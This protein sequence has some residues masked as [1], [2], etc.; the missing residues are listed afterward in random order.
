MAWLEDLPTELLLKILYFATHSDHPV[1]LEHPLLNWHCPSSMFFKRTR[2]LQRHSLSTKASIARVCHRWNELSLSWL[3]EHITIDNTRKLLSIPMNEDGTVSPRLQE[4]FATVRRLDVNLPKVEGVEESEETV[5]VRIAGLLKAVSKVTTLVLFIPPLHCALGILWC[6][7][8][9]VKRLYWIAPTVDETCTLSAARF[10]L[11]SFLDFLDRHPSLETIALPFVFP[12]SALHSM[13]KYAPRTPHRSLREIIVQNG[14]QWDLFSL[15]GIQHGI[16]PGVVNRTVTFDMESQDFS[17]TSFLGGASI[18]ITELSIVIH[19]V[20]RAWPPPFLLMNLPNIKSLCPNLRNFN[21]T[22]TADAQDIFAGPMDP[23]IVGVPPVPQV[24]SVSIQR[25]VKGENEMD[26]PEGTF[27]HVLLLPWVDMFPCLRCIRI[28]E[29]I[30]L[31]AVVAHPA[32]AIVRHKGWKIGIEDRFGESLLLRMVSVIATVN[33]LV[34]NRSHSLVDVNPFIQ[35]T[36][37]KMPVRMP[38]SHL[39]LRTRQTLLLT[40]LFFLSYFFFGPQHDAEHEPRLPRG[41]TTNRRRQLKPDKNNRLP[42]SGGFS[43]SSSPSSSPFRD[44]ATKKGNMARKEVWESGRL[45]KEGDFDPANPQATSGM[46]KIMK[47]ER[48]SLSFMN[49]ARGP[50]R[51]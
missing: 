22:L 45:R 21:F 12:P 17:M 46:S 6:I 24:T 23:V 13:A 20:D 8:I 31:E 33:A 30:D 40:H 51:G 4:L 10:Q 32:M 49:G 3:Y 36:L 9:S 15:V 19:L 28:R 43:S 48:E 41:N 42:T 14:V 11:R 47:Q 35:F 44:N 38:P 50:T 34:S 27:H 26:D 29:D 25:V 1:A 37:S 39:H 2:D 16:M 7:P 18:R 5:L